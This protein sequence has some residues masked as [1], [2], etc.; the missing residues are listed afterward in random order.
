MLTVQYPE[1]TVKTVEDLKQ[2]PMRGARSKI[3]TTLDAVA[4]VKMIPTPT[5]VDH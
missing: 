5:E 1:G 3:P 4:Q 2:I